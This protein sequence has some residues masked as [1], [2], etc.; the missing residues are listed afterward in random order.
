[1]NYRKEIDGLRAIA[2]LPVIFFHAGFDAVSGGYVGVDVFFVISGYLITSQIIADLD[3][4]TFSLAHFYERRVRRIVPAL[5]FMILLVLPFAVWYLTPDQVKD[6]YGSVVSVVLASSNFYFAADTGYFGAAPMEKPLLHTWSL[7]VEEQYYL[8]FPALMLIGWKHG[9]A[10]VL[11][12]LITIALLSLVAAELTHRLADPELSYFMTTGRVWELLL[13]ALLAFRSDQLADATPRWLKEV[14]A[15]AGLVL[16]G[17]AVMA[18]DK[19]TPSPG[20]YMLVPTIGAVLV[21]AYARKGT[22][23]AWILSLWPLAAIGVVSY[24][25]YLW[26]QPIFAIARVLSLYE[27]NSRLFGILGLASI[28]MGAISYWLVERPF[29]KRQRFSR[30]SVFA[31]AGV[32]AVVMFSIG[33]AGQ[34]YQ[35]A[36]H[37]SLLR[38][39]K[40][41]Q[42]ESYA[43]FVRNPE[44][45]GMLAQ[46]GESPGTRVLVIGDSHAKDMFNA[47]FI[48]ADQ[49]AEKFSFRHL[50]YSPGCVTSFSASG[51]ERSECDLSAVS[52]LLYEQADWILFSARWSASEAQQV[53]QFID[54]Y[55]RHGKRVIITSRTVEYPN[56]PVL[57]HRL[58]WDNQM[59]L[60]SA[61]Q[62]RK[63]FW[64]NRSTEV[65]HINLQLRAVTEGHHG[66]FLD[67]W[68]YACDIGREECHALDEG[69]LPLHYDYGHYTTEGVRFFGRRI[70]DNK[71][72]DKVQ[73]EAKKRD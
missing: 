24:S 7:S 14:A 39:W 27:P 3:A 70:I 42:M 55:Q 45:Q 37:P 29:R 58:Y 21:L 62:I 19:D 36:A 46:F 53:G 17:I 61:E 71:W 8:L 44:L 34:I 1:M 68:E 33:V 18:F 73:G 67:K 56:A 49:Q 11:K 66:V 32:C 12:W 64:E 9:R 22:W 52:P 30:R 48:S 15:V 5:V 10:H 20:L 59:T 65:E 28:A 16:I 2:V 50:N 31:G 41:K 13:G 54:Y 23:T 60:P 69:G 35:P 43:L 51:T 63:A 40:K 4:G 57:M 6:F 72:L 26:H 47:L 38:N 25:A